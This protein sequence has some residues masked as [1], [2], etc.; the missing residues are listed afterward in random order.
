MGNQRRIRVND[1]FPLYPELRSI[2]LKSFGLAEKIRDA[3]VLLAPDIQEAFIFGSV[4]KG[5]DRADSDI[6]VMIIGGLDLMP[7]LD[8]IAPVEKELGRRIN[9]NLYSPAEWNDLKVHDS[10][11]SQIITAAK[12]S[13]LPNA[14][15]D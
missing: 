9:V 4:A 1:R 15:T 12:L 5:E 2:C 13:L 10:V 3:L 7:I 6:D 14:S 8:A 11:V